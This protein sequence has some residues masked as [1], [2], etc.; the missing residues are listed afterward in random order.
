MTATVFLNHCGT[1]NNIK[2][3]I[4]NT[5]NNIKI[6]KKKNGEKDERECEHINLVSLIHIRLN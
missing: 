5:Q 6:K 3:N 1:I 4:C 2:F